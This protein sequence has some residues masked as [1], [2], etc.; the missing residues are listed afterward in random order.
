MKVG[1]NDQFRTECI[2]PAVPVHWALVL[3]IMILLSFLFTSLK[4]LLLTDSLCV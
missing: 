2:K 1:G 3:Q 4:N